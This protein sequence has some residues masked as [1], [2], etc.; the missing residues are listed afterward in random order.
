M[1]KRP[2]SDPASICRLLQSLGMK[3]GQ[4]NEAVAY[5]KTHPQLRLGEI[6]VKLGF[7]RPDKIHIAMSQQRAIRQRSVG[8]LVDLATKRTRTMARDTSALF[9]LSA[10]ALSKLHDPDR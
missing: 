2:G 8:Q 10:D 1:K 5:Q 4:L 6:C 3:R 7:I 9:H